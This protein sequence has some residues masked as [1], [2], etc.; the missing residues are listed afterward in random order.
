MNDFCSWKLEHF[1]RTNG[2]QASEQENSRETSPQWTQHTHSTYWIRVPSSVSDDVCV[3]VSSR[4]LQPVPPEGVLASRR[5]SQMKSKESEMEKT[6][7]RQA[8]GASVTLLQSPAYS[9]IADELSWITWLATIFK[10]TGYSWDIMYSR[11]DL[12][13]ST[14]SFWTYII[15]MYIL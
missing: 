7:C 6:V 2:D 5:T 4:R 12:P 11:D 8:F 14:L 3:C 10:F 13:I 15:R 9:S 1:P